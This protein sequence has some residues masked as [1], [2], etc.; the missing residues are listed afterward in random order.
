MNPD[1]DNSHSSYS[2]DLQRRSNSLSSSP[3]FPR[4]ATVHPQ[5]FNVR[6]AAPSEHYNHQ[7]QHLDS[8][9]SNAAGHSFSTSDGRLAPSAFNF[10]H[11]NSYSYPSTSIIA[12]AMQPRT[13]DILRSSPSE[14]SDQ[15]S[16][17]P[18]LPSNIAH[19]PAENLQP[20]S[21]D[22]S[23]RNFA[24]RTSEISIQNPAPGVCPNCSWYRCMAVD[25]K[26]LE[27]M[28]KGLKYCRL[29]RSEF[30]WHCV[31]RAASKEN[32]HGNLLDMWQSLVDSDDIWMLWDSEDEVAAWPYDLLQAMGSQGYTRRLD[33][34]CYSGIATII[35]RRLERHTSGICGFSTHSSPTESTDHPLVMRLAIIHWKT[36]LACMHRK[37]RSKYSPIDS[38]IPNLVTRWWDTIPAAVENDLLKITADIPRPWTELC[39]ILKRRGH[40]CYEGHPRE[41]MW[42]AWV[43]VQ[44]L[45]LSYLPGHPGCSQCESMS[46]ASL[47]GRP[48]FVKPHLVALWCI[49]KAMLPYLLHGSAI[50]PITTLDFW[51]AVSTPWIQLSHSILHPKYLNF[52]DE[53]LHK[54]PSD[55]EEREKDSSTITTHATWVPSWLYARLEE[56]ENDLAAHWS[57]IANPIAQMSGSSGLRG[58]APLNPASWICAVALFSVTRH[59]SLSTFDRL[60]SLVADHFTSI[61]SLSNPI[62]I[63]IEKAPKIAQTLAVKCFEDGLK[64]SGHTC[65]RSLEKCGE[66]SIQVLYASA[67]LTLMNKSPPV[68]GCGLPHICKVCGIEDDL[69]DVLLDVDREGIGEKDQGLANLR[70]FTRLAD[71]SNRIFMATLQKDLTPGRDDLSS[72]GSDSESASETESEASDPTHQEQELTN[73]D[74]RSQMISIPAA[75]ASPRLE[76][77]HLPVTSGEDH[78]PRPPELSMEGLHTL[79]DSPR[80]SEDTLILDMVVPSL[81]SRGISHSPLSPTIVPQQAL[82]SSSISIP[83]SSFIMETGFSGN[84]KTSKHAQKLRPSEL[85]EVVKEKLVS[86]LESHEFDV[87][88]Q[89]SHGKKTYK[90]P[91]SNLVDELRH[92][93]LEFE[94]WPKVK[95]KDGMYRP[96]K[97]AAP[98]GIGKAPLNE[99]EPLYNALT[100]EKKPLGIRKIVDDSGRSQMRMVTVIPSS[101]QGTKRSRDE[102]QDVEGDG[103][104]VKKRAR[105]KE[106]SSSRT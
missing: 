87:S 5:M 85:R 12:P 67:Y 44:D 98:N 73:E 25:R 64:R 22:V 82:S 17:L 70:N 58:K 14:S 10:S 84:S 80:P 75:D 49:S 23:D 32:D 19:S 7:S 28:E 93:G 83:T 74:L 101:G 47:T 56:N 104:S 102:E 46:R 99:L 63:L 54:L 15:H 79:P 96:L 65:W 90:L 89:S 50:M 106:S 36:I 77:P 48:D 60:P 38:D 81:T 43:T 9:H 6:S 72:H 71:L 30:L 13:S 78:I 61:I 2:A 88:V 21:S 51:S 29:R 66:N 76:Q 40:S 16:I 4:A 105:H 1:K 52:I 69:H 27:A 55:N 100:N 31:C 18:L 8:F 59:L 41:S 39:R 3:S 53:W 42:R 94:N 11:S 34:D 86:L 57:E 62:R 35:S 33:N 91:W 24:T 97:L 92:T 68:T 20:Q 45:R 37:Y 95:G 103:T 26:F